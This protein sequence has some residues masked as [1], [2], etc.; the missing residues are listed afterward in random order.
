ML[1]PFQREV[2]DR[3]GKYFPCEKLIGSLADEQKYICH[4]DNLKYMRDK[5]VRIT[6]VHWIIVYDQV[7]FMRDY[8][9]RQAEIRAS[10]LSEPML[11]KVYKDSINFFFG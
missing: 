6:K 5:G 4:K 2:L 10:P 1:S 3:N 9:L 11:K 7:P 8:V